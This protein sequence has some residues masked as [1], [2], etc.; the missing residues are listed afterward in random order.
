MLLLAFL[1]GVL[2]IL[3]PCVLPLVPI[4]LA[5]ALPEHRLAPVALAGGLAVSFAGIGLLMAVIGF[6]M[7]LDAN[8]FRVVASV[9]LIVMGTLLVSERLQFRAAAIAGPL[10]NWANGTQASISIQRVPGQFLVG[11]LLGL[12]WTPCVGPTLGAASVM[13]MR[14]ENLATAI[15]TMAVFGIGA[16]VPLLV[17]GLMSSQLLKHWNQRIFRAAPNIKIALGLL[18]VAMGLMSL[19]GWDRSVQTY[20]E[21]ITPDWLI[22]LTTRL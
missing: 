16:A 2:S 22:S 15:A 7:G 11:L 5:G 13:A 9:M 8:L 14:G 1:A 3:S 6:S 17:L 20:L 18:L 10:A 12:V 21:G 4:I 19:T